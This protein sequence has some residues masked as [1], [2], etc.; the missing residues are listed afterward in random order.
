MKNGSSQPST[1]GEKDEED[2]TMMYNSLFGLIPDRKKLP[3]AQTLTAVFHV[4]S[5][6]RMLS[7]SH[8]GAG[9]GSQLLDG[10]HS[11]NL[12]DKG[13]HIF[14]RDLLFELQGKD[15]ARAHSLRR[16]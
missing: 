2:N 15:C 5:Y 11:G 1:A 4:F 10:G 14:M 7:R 9:R 3:S 13:H 16:S 12:G 6:F 8:T